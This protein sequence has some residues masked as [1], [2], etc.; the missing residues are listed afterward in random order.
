[1]NMRSIP[2]RTTIVAAVEETATASIE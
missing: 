1:M 2:D